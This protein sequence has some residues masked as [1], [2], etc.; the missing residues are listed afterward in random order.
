L[1]NKGTKSLWQDLINFTKL[2]ET[3]AMGSIVST[4]THQFQEF[5]SE[6]ALNTLGKAIK[7]CVREREIT[8]YRLTL[9]LV[10]A[11]ATTKLDTIADIHRTFNALCETTVQYKPFYNQLAKPTFPLLMRS[12]CEQTMSQ[13][14]TQVLRFKPDSPFA[15]FQQIILHDGSSF[16]VKSTLASEFPGRFTTI[17]PAAVELHVSM[18]LYHESL[19]T[20][21]LTADSESEVHHVP[22]AEHLSG[23]L[24]IGDRMFFIKSYLAEVLHC[25]GSFIVKTKGTLNPIIRHAY[26]VNGKERLCY[27][28]QPLN[29]LKSKVSW[30]KSLDLEVEWPGELK[31]RL[32]ITWDKKNRRPRYLITNL[33]RADFTLEQICDAYRLRWQVELLFKEWKS[34]ANLQAFETSNAD[35]A[36][37]FIWAAL[38]AAIIKR[39]CAHQ[40]QYTHRVAISTR[41]AA[42]CLQQHLTDIFRALLHT[43]QCLANCIE[44]ALRYLAVN[45]KRAHPKRDRES[46][47]LKL[48]IEPVYALA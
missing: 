3:A 24:F 10:N 36:E 7:F 31:A 13:F 16:G 41:T 30:Y 26:T 27:R 40:A 20:V 32:I 23:S 21:M 37:G 2:N 18:D 39:Y 19:E 8:P 46:G 34:Y 6:Q 43:P 35:I 48:D 25:G 47:R 45:A 4:I 17:S 22:A 14:T 11:F 33:S 42:M 5:F 28:D 15:Q 29:S 9:G 38:V 1:K 12:V 44:R